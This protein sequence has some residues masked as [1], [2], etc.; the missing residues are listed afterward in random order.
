MDISDAIVHGNWP[1]VANAYWNPAYA[2]ALAAGQAIA[3]PSR[4]NELQVF[5]WTNFVI[6]AFCV[7]ATIYFARSLVVL[8][9][10][11]TANVD[12]A[13]NPVAVVFA[14][15]SLM[16]FSFQR[17]LSL[18][19]VRSDAL[20]YLFL[21]LA[22]SLLMRIQV[23]RKFIYF[24]LLG[25][26]LGLAYLTKSFAM[27]PSALLMLAILIFGFRRKGADRI[28]IVAGTMTCALV[29]TV[30][31][32]PYVYA[33][34][35]QRGRFTIGDSARINY[36]FYV[37]GNTNWWA[38]AAGDVHHARYA[39][40]HPEQII[41]SNPKT[42]S[43]AR[44]MVGTYPFW[45][46]PSYWLDTI[47][48]QFYLKGH[49][50]QA[51]QSAKMSFIYLFDHPEA[52][53]LGFVL[54][55]AGARFPR[56]RSTWAPFLPVMAWG[57][58]MIGIYFPLTLEERYITFSFLFIVIPLLALLVR[59]EG[60]DRLHEIA[61][62]I[63]LLLACVSLFSGLRDEFYQRRIDKIAFFPLHH[64]QPEIFSAARGLANLGIRPSDRIACMGELGCHYDIYWI[65]LAG[66][67]VVDEISVPREGSS[68]GDPAA[69]WRSL[70]NAS[71]VV[72]VLQRDGA[73][74]LVSEFP[75]GALVPT[76]W[77]NLPGSRFYVLALTSRWPGR[78]G[79]ALESAPS[80]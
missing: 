17:E 22:A 33:I 49:I 39:F 9:E 79:Q 50:Q 59:P 77:H 12:F 6:F 47:Y 53:L 61:T 46:D 2:F 13:L 69:Y 32:G 40:K 71:E 37:D 35:Q 56:T 14:A 23:Q 19:K 72:D 54:L 57:L 76:G 45:F 8:R 67:Q 16:F 78:R 80:D 24:P 29:F 28:R 66:L 51:L 64:L 38:W 7:A 34:S 41:L 68:P 43:F 74:A 58:V 42:H 5:Y 75:Q 31:A 52:F 70:Q 11:L 60:R 65:R 10:R 44:H 27:I 21:F 3:H 62:A 63:V 55:L 30:L 1:I 18:A 25:A 36:V 15:L 26:A 48:P 73:T 20:L 4:W